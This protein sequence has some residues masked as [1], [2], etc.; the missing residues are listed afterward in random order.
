MHRGAKVS[1][2][3]CLQIKQFVKEVRMRII[4]IRSRIRTDYRH[5]GYII[6]VTWYFLFI[7]KAC[8]WEWLAPQTKKF[9]FDEDH[10]T[11]ILIS[12]LNLYLLPLTSFSKGIALNSI[13]TS[14]KWLF[15]NDI[16]S[17]YN[18][19]YC[20]WSKSLPGNI[21]AQIPQRSYWSFGTQRIIEKYTNFL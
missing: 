10:D 11:V 7:K 17:S 2:C 14:W 15:L 19:N 18:Y 5:L 21:V 16:S 8:E 4:M 9:D 3:S 6:V 1:Q 13:N 12:R 20:L